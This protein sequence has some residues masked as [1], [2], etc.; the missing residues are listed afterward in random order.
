[1]EYVSANTVCCALM[2]TLVLT[3]NIIVFFLNAVSMAVFRSAV[4]TVPFMLS[5][6]CRQH[7]VRASTVS[8]LVLASLASIIFTDLMVQSHFVGSFIFLSNN[9]HDITIGFM[10]HKSLN[11][12]QS[13]VSTI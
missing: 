11:I 7:E 13:S 8:S 9:H 1:M 2:L 12:V 4:Y 10:Q 6:R 3:D 5:S